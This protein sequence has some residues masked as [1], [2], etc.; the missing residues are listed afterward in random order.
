MCK[1]SA[2]FLAQIMA[3]IL[4]KRGFAQTIVQIPIAGIKAAFVNILA[5]GRARTLTDI[6]SDDTTV[7]V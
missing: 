3:F 5:T 7:Q 4:R 6:F 1:L 2:K